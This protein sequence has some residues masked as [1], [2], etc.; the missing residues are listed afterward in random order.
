MF[1]EICYT[2]ASRVH[3]ELE[4]KT[5]VGRD[6]EQS[7]TG[8]RVKMA[9]PHATISKLDDVGMLPLR[10]SLLVEC[11][12]LASTQYISLPGRLF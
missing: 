9:E 11:D 7:L 4:N 5:S 3:E 10:T 1:R 12:N 6:S 8:P 2:V